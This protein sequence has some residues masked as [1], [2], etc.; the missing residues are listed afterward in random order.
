MSLESDIKR[1]I[2]ATVKT[3]GRLDC[4]VKCQRP[5]A[6]NGRYGD[7]RDLH[8]RDGL[9]AR[10]GGVRH[11]LRRAR[12]EGAGTRL[13]HQQRQRRSGAHAYR[14]ILLLDRE[15]RSRSRNPNGGHGTR[16]I[17]H[18]RELGLTPRDRHT[19]LLRWLGRVRKSR[20]RTRHGEACQAHLKPGQGDAVSAVRPAVRHRRRSLVPGLR[21]RR[22]RQLPRLRCRWRHERGRANELRVIARA[23][24]RLSAPIMGRSD[25]QRFLGPPPPAHLRS[26]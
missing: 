20:P 14:P 8:L 2:D 13:R 17:W 9:A 7:A 24:R 12:D 10:F 1:A 16:P 19:H 6:G 21:G 3:F 18:K 25:G 23:G 5:H 15:G 26:G 11:A 22:L 4:L